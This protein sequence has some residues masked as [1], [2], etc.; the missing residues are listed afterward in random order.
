VSVGE[1]SRAA[2]DVL[3]S[4]GFVFCAHFGVANAEFVLATMDR[5]IEQGRLYEWL[6]I[7]YGL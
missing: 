6:H 3:G 1:A 5:A 4:R 7:N 2:M